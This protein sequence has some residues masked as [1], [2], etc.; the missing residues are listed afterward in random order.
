MALFIVYKDGSEQQLHINS[1]R[2]KTIEGE[3]SKVSADGHE[4]EF[5]R[6][7]FHNLP[8]LSPGRLVTWPQPWAGF[9]IENL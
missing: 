4:L 3:V 7:R 5:I 1:P 8:I 2:P 9:I 6:D